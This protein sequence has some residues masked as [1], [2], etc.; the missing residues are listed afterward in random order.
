MTA[1]QRLVVVTATVLALASA[2][3]PA[4]IADPILPD[5]L[6]PTASF[7]VSPNPA[8]TGQTV[9]F[10]GTGSWDLDGQITKYEWDLDG[11]GSYETDTDTAASTSTTYSSPGTIDVKLRVTDNDGKTDEADASL[12][13]QSPPTASFDF[14]PPSPSTGETITFTSDSTDAD[15]TIASEAWDFNNDG[16]FDDATGSSPTTSFANPGAH[17]VSLRVVDD[18]GLSDITTRIVSVE[19]RAPTASFDFSPSSPKT[20]E[21]ITFSSSSSDP[22]GPLQSQ[23]WDFDNDGE[24]DDGSGASPTWAFDT[25]GSKTV[26]LKVTDSDG[27]SDVATR[28]VSV[29]NR[30]PSAS[31]DFSPQSP[32][33]D[34]TVTFTATATDPDGS[35]TK[36][37][38]DFNNDGSFDATGSIAPKSFPTAGQKTVTLKVT[39][40]SGG[41]ATASEVV[42][43]RNRPPTSSDGFTYSPSEF[44]TGEPVTFTSTF[45]DPDGSIVSHEWNFGDGSTGTGGSPDHTY[46]QPGAY[47]VTLTVTDNDGATASA[48][49]TVV[50]DNRPPTASFT[51]TP[52]SPLSIQT[53]DFHSTSTDDDG[54]NAYRWDFQN[55]G[56]VDSTTADTAFVYAAPGTYT[57]KLEVEDTSGATAVK[58]KQLVIGNRDPTASFSTASASPPAGDLTLE[59][60]TFTSTSTD[61]DGAVQTYQWDTDNDGVYDDGIGPTAT[62]QFPTSGTYTVSLR[63]IDDLGAQSTVTKSIT[64]GNRAPK[65]SFFHSPTF[66]APFETVAFTSSSG[67]LDGTIS[68]LEWDLDNDGSFDDGTSAKA[69][70]KFT[71]SGSYTVSLRATD[72]NGDSS[73]AAETIFVGNRPPVASFSYSP[74]APVAGQTVSFFSTS[75]DPDSP[76]STYAWDLDGDG[77]YNDAGG[78][79][80]ARAFATGS[81]NVGIMVV[82]SEGAASF[83]AQTINVRAPDVA[84]PAPTAPAAISAGPRLMSPF[85]VVRIAGSILRR[86]IKLRRLTVSGPTGATV[87]VSCKGRGCPVGRQSRVVKSGKRSDSRSPSA[88]I[89]R[90]RRFER[91]LLRSGTVIKILVTKP[92]S[93]GKYTRFKIRSRKPPARSDRCLMPNSTKPVDCPAA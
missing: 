23:E 56:I 25:P 28:T 39:D 34:Q 71:Q 74:G 81:H 63:V 8:Q 53:V 83:M 36:Y 19:N 92:N 80:A 58:T 15:G 89:V 32:Q 91:K 2:P 60:I 44:S 77:N 65:V 7:T 38:W 87:L 13:V 17:Q 9:A 43:V 30:P 66:P 64:I 27:A 33:T 84:A 3:A 85:P 78:P 45:T 72:D 5:P 26:K 47:L 18:D 41:T 20:N 24:Y 12:T 1:K 10:D 61:P 16:Q 69:T 40:D 11:D 6:A 35:I 51:I 73:V 54:I 4:A 29:A 14:S 93:I 46:S 62:R 82:D 90:L 88:Q 57:V 79:S 70:K 75:T 21:T 86:G 55:D 42:T 37:Q 50:T 22:E 48:Q 68:K 49:K 31:F 59:D 76:I 52:S 67:D